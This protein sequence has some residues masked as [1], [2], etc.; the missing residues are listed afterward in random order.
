[1]GV[2]AGAGVAVLNSPA[3][4]PAPPLA[5]S[6]WVTPRLLAGEYPGADTAAG[7]T[8]RLEALIAAGITYFI[9]LTQP[10]ELPPYDHLLPPALGSMVIFMLMAAI[11][12]WRPK[13][14]FP[15]HG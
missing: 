4:L 3:E 11:L 5:G 15:V 8:A 1:M 6:Y 7:A 2:A 14:L 13:G 12:A 10:G 9:D